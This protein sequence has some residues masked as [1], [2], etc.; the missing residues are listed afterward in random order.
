MGK[1]D[2]LLGSSLEALGIVFD[3]NQMARLNA[4]IAEIELWNPTYKLVGAQG[5]DLITR[6][7]IDSLSAVPVLRGLLDTLGPDARIADLGSGAGLPGIPLAIALQEH[8]FT[9]VE[10]M[11]RRVGFLRNALAICRLGERVE[12]LDRDLKDV[13]QTFDLIT[14]RAFRPLPDILDLVEPILTPTGVICAYKGQAASLHEELEKVRLVCTS[15]WTTAEVSL[16]VPYLEAERM[17]CLLE[18]E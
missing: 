7:I 5:E 10:R 4:Y 9:L 18:K 2:G 11:E 6:H 13:E 3:Q 14:F 16:D 17:L 8:H 15:A 12:V 1:Y